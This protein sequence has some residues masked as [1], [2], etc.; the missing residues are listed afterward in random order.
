MST[1]RPRFTRATPV[2]AATDYARAR[3][4]YTERLGFRVIEEGGDPPGF[5]IFARD[6]AYLFI[7]SFGEAPPTRPG[8]RWQAYLH[9]NEID[10]LRAELIAAG[11]E[12]AVELHETAYG[13]RE[14]EFDDPEGNRI[15]LGWTTSPCLDVARSR[16]VLAVPD[17]E[18]TR[19]WFEAVLGCQSEDID[20]GNWLLLRLYGASFMVGRCPD[21]PAVEAIGDHG[22]VAYLVVD[23]LAA[24][25]ARAKAEGAEI[26]KASRDEPWGMRELGLRSVDGHRIML[27]QA[28]STPG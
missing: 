13:M 14:L 15:C 5:G 16:H 27:A 25:E 7:D 24:F 2:L 23:D 12:L 21:A 22:Y 4:F 6:G 9:V 8:D 18:R 28:I 26:V 11:V 3:R 1:L 10:Q 19:R 17:L 20:P